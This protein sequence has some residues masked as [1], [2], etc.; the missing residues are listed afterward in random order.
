MA[1]RIGLKKA[2]YRKKNEPRWKNKI[3][4]DIKRLRQEVNF[5][6]GEPR[7]ELELKKILKFSELN[8]RYRVKRKALKSVTDKQKQ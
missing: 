1:E 7:E 6:E 3:E 4:R 8:E 2:E 5:M